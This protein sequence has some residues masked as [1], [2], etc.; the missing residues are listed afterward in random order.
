MGAGLYENIHS[1]VA[2]SS[3][4]TMLSEA[5]SEEGEGTGGGI[6]PDKIVRENG[7]GTGGGMQPDGDYAGG[8]AENSELREGSEAWPIYAIPTKIAK[9][10]DL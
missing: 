9:C 10:A 2:Q 1:I 6:Q 7:E 3:P 4:D 8:R 5:V